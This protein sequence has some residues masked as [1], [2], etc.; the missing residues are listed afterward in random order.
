MSEIARITTLVDDTAPAR[1]LLGEHGLAFWIEYGGRNVLFDTGQ[2][3]VLVHNA[4][5]LGIDLALADAIVLSHGHYDH[6]GGLEIALQLA[7]RARVFVHP[8]ALGRRYRRGPDGAAR[9]IGMPLSAEELVRAR[10]DGVVF[11]ERATEVVTGV[12]VTGTIAR[13]TRFEGSD[14]Q[15]YRDAD[16]AQPDLLRDDQALYFNCAAGVVVVLG[17]AHSGVINTINHV[18]GQNKERPLCALIGGMHLGS[19]SEARLFATLDALQTHELT[20]IAPAHCT[21]AMQKMLLW[22]RFANRCR[23]CA[24]GSQFVFENGALDGQ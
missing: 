20:M 14:E 2:T 7:P 24:V 23:D 1:G 10:T 18:R 21:G 8:E 22:S 15:F 16:C 11:T 5:R 19:A 13:L 17:C 12:C 3:G 4:A 9:E 6:T